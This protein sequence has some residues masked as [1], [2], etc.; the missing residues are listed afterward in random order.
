MTPK[1]GAVGPDYETT[2]LTGALTVQPNA[3]TGASTMGPQALTGR[4][5]M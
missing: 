2:G 5:N 4:P 3:P 1:D